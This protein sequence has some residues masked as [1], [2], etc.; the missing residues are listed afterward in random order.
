MATLQTEARLSDPDGFY[1][2]LIAMHNDLTEAQ[3]QQVN[4]RL[5]LLLSNQIGD[6]EILRAAMRVA[7]EGVVAG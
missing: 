4:A 6:A 7:R 3:S 1:E 2:A 5:I